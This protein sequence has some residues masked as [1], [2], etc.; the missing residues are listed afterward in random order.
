MH[1]A[2][3]ALMT[4]VAVCTAAD[5]VITIAGPT[6]GLDDGAYHANT[7]DAF[8][9]TGTASHPDG[10]ASVAWTADGGSLTVGGNATGTTAWSF[11]FLP[12]AYGLAR[13]HPTERLYNIRV[14]ATAVGGRT[15][16][17]PLVITLENQPPGLALN[18]IPDGGSLRVRV[19]Q[20]PNLPGT[21]TDNG[22]LLTVGWSLSGGISMSGAAVLNVPSFLVG[23]PAM[24]SG[25]SV[26]TLSANDRAGNRTDIT[27]TLVGDPTAPVIT[28]TAPAA[29]GPVTV[30]TA[31]PTIAGTATDAELLGPSPHAWALSGATTG[32][33]LLMAGPAWSFTPT[34]SPGR[35]R[36]AVTTSDAAGWSTTSFLDIDYTPGAPVL[37]LDPA[38]AALASSLLTP[39]S[40]LT[41][42]G[43]AADPDGI[44][45]IAWSLTGATA[46]TGT[47]TGTAT[48]SLTTPPLA[49]GNISLT[50][51]ATDGSGIM[52]VLPLGLTVG[53][54]SGSSSTSGGDPGGGGGGGGCGIGSGA[55]LI[56]LAGCLAL[57]RRRA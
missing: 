13:N 53:T 8:T 48:W 33:G 51:T 28:F 19:G 11:S 52:T 9:I 10:I 56:L 31:T 29:T 24:P 12:F 39:G 14:T 41:L 44:A 20:A 45:G 35:T 25:S 7:G 1:I 32:N 57:R 34:L 49:A 46:A 50:L 23:L 55:G 42:S 17:A 5:P 2:V 40:A 38:S 18:D 3:L 36:V 30:T 43:T 47:A 15:A 21:V 54:P 16:D 27:A 22:Q 6:N 26:L 37:Q 4:A